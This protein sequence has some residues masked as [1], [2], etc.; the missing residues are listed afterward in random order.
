MMTSNAAEP[1]TLPAGFPCQLGDVVM[2]T[3]GEEAWLAGAL[4]LSEEEPVAVLFVA[5]DAGRN[6]WLFAR[7]LPAQAILWL[8]SI[9]ASTILVGSE[10][11]TSVDHEGTRFERTRRLPLTPTRIGTGAPDVGESLILAEYTSAGAERL[12]VIKGSRANAFA[13]RGEELAPLSYEVVA[14]G[15]ATL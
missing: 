3:T 4:V 10:P 12:V 1:P 2:R 5:P 15:R 9:D 7:P 8:E 13:F 11:P 6:T 14:S